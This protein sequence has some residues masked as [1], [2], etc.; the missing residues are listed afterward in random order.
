MKVFFKFL[1]ISTFVLSTRLVKP[2]KIVAQTIEVMDQTEII[3]DLMET[4]KPGYN[5][6]F[7]PCQMVSKLEVLSHSE[8]NLVK[9]RK[10]QK[11]LWFIPPNDTKFTLGQPKDY[12]VVSKEFVRQSLRKSL[13]GLLRINDFRNSTESAL[14][15]FVDA[16]DEFYKN[17]LGEV[18]NELV[19]N[20]LDTEYEVEIGTLEKA[21]YGLTKKSLLSLHNYY[22]REIK[23]NRN[24]VDDFRTNFQEYDKVMQ[25]N[26]KPYVLQMV[27][28]LYDFQ[29]LILFCRP[30]IKEEDL[31]SYLEYSDTNNFITN[32][33]GIAATTT[34]FEG[35]ETSLGD[36]FENSYTESGGEQNVQQGS[37]F[38][39]VDDDKTKKF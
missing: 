23:K 27:L 24:E 25:I 10:F 14:A 38:M 34:M 31:A 20:N 37:F 13:A 26:K 29:Y 9:D 11:P 4:Y 16:I 22:R 6:V 30:N 3:K 28:V 12:N 33:D 21:Y 35:G 1:V 36:I 17:L 18:R 5:Y 7:N 32:P 39:W 19:T 8:I 15:L 2:N